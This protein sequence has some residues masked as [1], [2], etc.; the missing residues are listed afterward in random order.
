MHHLLCRPGTLHD[1]VAILAVPQ[2]QVSLPLE[3][4]EHAAEGA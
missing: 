1:N 4:S 3:V 2:L